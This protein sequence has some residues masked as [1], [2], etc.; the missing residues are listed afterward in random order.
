MKMKFQV[1]ELNHEELVNLFSTATYGNNALYI[2]V[3]EEYEELEDKG[4]GNCIEDKWANVLANGGQL[5]VYDLYDESDTQEEAEYYGNKG[6]NW[7]DT[8]WKPMTQYIVSPLGEAVHQKTNYYPTYRIT[9][10]TLLNGISNEYAS[11]YVKE[12]FIDE[13]GDLYT[14]WNIMQIAVFGEIIYG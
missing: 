13:A 6:T 2:K 1:T 7:V 5:E 12:L 4:E 9:M 14:A 8:G 11:S 10:E 3:P